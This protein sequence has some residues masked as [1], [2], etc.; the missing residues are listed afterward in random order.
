MIQ[1][2]KPGTKVSGKHSSST[3]LRPASSTR[4]QAF[5]IHAARS[6]RIDDVCAAAT[7]CR[8]MILPSVYSTN[9][10]KVLSIEHSVNQTIAIG[11]AGTSWRTFSESAIGA[12]G[13][14]PS[15]DRSVS[16]SGG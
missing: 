6:I 7:T 12:A 13:E 3:P 11:W 15:T 16:L 5:A 4:V 10:P 8:L 2:G 14:R 9:P 1:Y